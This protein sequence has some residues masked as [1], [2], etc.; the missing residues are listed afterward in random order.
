[1]SGHERW[2]LSVLAAALS[3]IQRVKRTQG[4]ID[5]LV[6]WS[7]QDLVNLVSEA[8]LTRDPFVT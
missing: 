1:M 6:N 3:D 2:D 5:R 4:Y 8:R 7:V